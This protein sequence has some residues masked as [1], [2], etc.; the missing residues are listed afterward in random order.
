M[1]HLSKAELLLAAKLLEDASEQYSNHGCNDYPIKDTPEHRAILIAQQEYDGWTGEEI[2]VHAESG[3]I[4][5]SDDRLM[6]Y[7]AHRLKEAAK[8][9]E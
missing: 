3:R 9:R 5:A 7:L 2:E 8:V 1:S 4:T 6:D